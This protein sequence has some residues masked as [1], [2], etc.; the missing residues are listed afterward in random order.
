MESGLN[1]E[2]VEVE[3]L[4]EETFDA[5]VFADPTGK[6]KRRFRT[7]GFLAGGLGV[8]YAAMLGLSFA[9]GPIAPNALLPIPGV[10]TA[11][12]LDLGSDEPDES[13]LSPISDGQ[14]DRDGDRIDR[15]PRPGE[16][17]SRNPSATPTKPGPSK[18]T[19]KP[20]LVVP[21]PVKPTPTTKAPEPP[22]PTTK[23]PE[24]PPPTT[25]APEPEPTTKAPDPTPEDP[26]PPTNNPTTTGSGTGGGGAPPPADPPPNTPPTIPEPTT[27]S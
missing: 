7:V 14:V 22:P 10:P 6:R 18:T 2:T 21:T 23:A 9:G 13:A 1:S 26:T 8:A 15:T 12:P 5:P 20:V 27:E 3:V 19:G 25:K 4:S 24:P 11:A 16:S 17:V